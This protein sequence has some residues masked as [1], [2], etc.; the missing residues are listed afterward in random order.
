MYYLKI[1][2]QRYK[3]AVRIVLYNSASEFYECKRW[4]EIFAAWHILRISGK[5]AESDRIIVSRPHESALKNHPSVYMGNRYSTTRGI[6]PSLEPL[7]YTSRGIRARTR[8]QCAYIVKNDGWWFPEPMTLYTGRTRTRWVWIAENSGRWF[9][10]SMTAYPRQQKKNQEAVCYMSVLDFLL[11]TPRDMRICMR[12]SMRLK[13]PTEIILPRFR[14]EWRKSN[15][16]LAK[17]HA[18]MIVGKK[19][20]YNFI[21]F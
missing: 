16:L 20:L 9:S 7:R 13:S 2:L 15:R 14:W 8:A 5:M 4:H 10:D 1:N 18:N 19:V 11:N 21:K 3:Y 17:I 6:I 12:V